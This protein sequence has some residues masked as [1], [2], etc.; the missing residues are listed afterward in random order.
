M[1]TTST[2]TLYGRTPAGFAAIAE[3]AA[4]VR[5][6]GDCAGY[7]AVAAGRAEAMIDTLVNPWDIAPMAVI[8]P[9][10]GGLLTTWSGDEGAG[11]DAVASNGVVHQELL[12]TLALQG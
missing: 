2:S 1:L 5:T 12:A 9:E 3:R 11:G 7:L 4:L 6:W 10:A 8:I